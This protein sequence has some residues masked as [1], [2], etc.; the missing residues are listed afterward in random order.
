MWEDLRACELK[1]LG[2]RI[3][4][5]VLVPWNAF[6]LCFFKLSRSFSILIVYSLMAG[7]SLLPFPFPFPAFPSSLVS[8]MMRFNDG[9]NYSMPHMVNEKDPPVCCPELT[10]VEPHLLCSLWG[11]HFSVD[12]SLPG[13]TFLLFQSCSAWIL[14]SQFIDDYVMRNRIK[15]FVK[16]Q[17]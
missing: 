15:S 5:V 6:C 13:M 3:A 7:N 14:F 17:I 2:E 1:M 8:L 10:T 11:W 4:C 16:I 12:S 9:A